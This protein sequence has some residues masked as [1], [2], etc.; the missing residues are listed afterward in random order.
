MRGSL[1]CLIFLLL[2]LLWHISRKW[3]C[4]MKTSWTLKWTIL[5]LF[6]VLRSIVLHTAAVQRKIRTQHIMIWIIFYYIRTLVS[7]LICDCT[8]VC[9]RMSVWTWVVRHNCNIAVC[10]GGWRTSITTT[11]SVQR[12]RDLSS[13]NRKPVYPFTYNSLNSCE[14]V[15]LHA[16]DCV[17]GVK[18]AKLCCSLA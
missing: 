6:F 3:H 16:Q 11:K 15:C 18:E 10:V 8:Y 2:T 13:K 1:L 17:L 12:C 7:H 9:V 5:F 14:C 4:D